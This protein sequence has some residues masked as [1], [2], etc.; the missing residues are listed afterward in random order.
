METH[1]GIFCEENWHS[2][3]AFCIYIAYNATKQPGSMTLENGLFSR[4]FG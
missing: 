2:H 1:V 4:D 3:D